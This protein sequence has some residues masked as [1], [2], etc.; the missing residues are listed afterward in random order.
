M[1]VYRTEN[2]KAGIVTEAPRF[3]DL[4]PVVF[5][6]EREPNAAR[7]TIFSI[8]SIATMVVLHPD[9]LAELREALS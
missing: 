2:E 6:I 4:G 9:K 3:I 1:S 8:A 5:R 7:L